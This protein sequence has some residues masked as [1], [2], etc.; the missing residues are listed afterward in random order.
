VRKLAPVPGMAENP[1]SASIESL[2]HELRGSASF[3]LGIHEVLDQKLPDTAQKLWD[4]LGR[5][6]EQVLIDIEDQMGNILA[7]ID[8]FS[9]AAAS[10]RIG[11]LASSWE[12][13]VEQ[14]SLIA[15]KVS[16]L[17]IQLA[18]SNLNTILNE[19]LP[20]SIRGFGRIVSLGKQIR[21]EDLSLG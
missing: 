1:L 15:N 7:N 16:D 21:P 12:N 13:K 10:A 3:I 18:D 2:F 14:L 8:S 6:S 11:G 19:Y 20:S 4:D 5:I 17:H 9:P